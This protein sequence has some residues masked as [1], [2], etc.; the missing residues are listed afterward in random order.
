MAVTIV[1]LYRGHSCETYVGV[2]EGHLTWEQQKEIANQ[3][4]LE[5]EDG[6]ALD[7]LGFTTMAVVPMPD[8]TMVPCPSMHLSNAFPEPYGTW[9]ALEDATR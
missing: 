8:A 5:T 4:E 1:T 9:S 6:E 2:V 7:T 3:L